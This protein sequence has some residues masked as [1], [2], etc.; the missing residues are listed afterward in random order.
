[1]VELPEFTT[2]WIE[3]WPQAIT[4]MSFPHVGIRLTTAQVH[5]IGYVNGIDRHCFEQGSEASLVDLAR[6][7]DDAF[8]AFPRGAFVR[9]G[10]RSPKD[11]PLGVSTGCRAM[12]GLAAV[13]LLT[14]GS[15]RIAFDLRRCLR[16]HYPPWIFLR[17]WQEIDGYSEFRCFWLNGRLAGASQYYHRYV[18]PAQQRM[19][20][21]EQ[22]CIAITSFVP[23]FRSAWGQCDV[24]FDVWLATAAFD[25][26]VILIELNP[27]VPATDSCLFSWQDQDFDDS[28]RIRT[29]AGIESYKLS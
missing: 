15:R 26:K 1:L 11:T 23:R 2:S 8:I 14:A 18:L 9:L 28:L 20:F 6:T 13:R 16:H 22:T 5:A 17:A 4:A 7:L 27:C 3:N 19:Q 25:C 12:T 10:S 29:E 24:V 21:I